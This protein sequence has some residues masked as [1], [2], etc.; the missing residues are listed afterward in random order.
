MFPI[1]QKQKN[2]NNKKKLEPRALQQLAWDRR[3]AAKEPGLSIFHT[4]A[5]D[6]ILRSIYN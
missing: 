5:P 1:K 3:E 6:S 2:N 4:L